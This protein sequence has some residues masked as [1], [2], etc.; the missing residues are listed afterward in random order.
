MG[1]VWD[2]DLIVWEKT[3]GGGTEGK[4]DACAADA[5]AQ[6]IS[7]IR[8]IHS[9]T[10]CRGGDQG[11]TSGLE[12]KAPKKSVIFTYWTACV[13]VHM[14]SRGMS[15]PTVS[16]LSLECFLPPRY[17]SWES[18]SSLSSFKHGAAVRQ[19]VSGK[20]EIREMHATKKKLSA[21]QL[22]SAG[23]KIGVKGQRKEVHHQPHRLLLW[24]FL[25]I[26]FSTTECSSDFKFCTLN[27]AAMA[28]H[29]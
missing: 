13:L 6:I 22:L 5:C 15:A 28:A 25:L 16:S 17:V 3:K 4:T 10:K 12:K 26:A 9:G 14:L 21:L 19:R 11:N 29:Q 24:P 7:Q 23:W 18:R 2:E 20:K 8:F 27:M 1:K